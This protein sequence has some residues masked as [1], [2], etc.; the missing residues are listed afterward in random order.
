MFSRTFT[1][2][3]SDPRGAAA[4]TGTIDNL[5][6]TESAV[7]G[8]V[9]IGGLL[10]RTITF[11]AFSRTAPIGANVADISKARARY[12]GAQTD[13]ARRADTTDVA[14][15]F[16]IVNAGGLYDPNGGFLFIS[17]AAYAGANTSG[18]LQLLFEETV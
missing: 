15:S 3:D 16:T 10:E 13:L 6:N 8:S 4:V 5:A 7:T 11:D 12:A 9:T 17:D 1:V 14:A 18:T 2:S